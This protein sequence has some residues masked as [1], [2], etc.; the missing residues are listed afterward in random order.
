MANF[1]PLQ[2]APID[3]EQTPQPQIRPA[4]IQKPKRTVTLG[5]CVA[6]RKRKSKCDG[7]RPVCTCCAQKVTECVYELGPNEK[8]SQ[9]MKRKNEEMQSEL[10]NLRQ[11][12]DCLRL[13]PE[14]EAQQVLRRIRA[15]SSDT[16]PSQRIQELA[17]FVRHGDPNLILQPSLMQSPRGH[18]E[19]LT[20][21]PIRMALDATCA[22]IDSFSGSLPSFSNDLLPMRSDGPASQRRR[23]ASDADVS[24]RSDSQGTFPP[25]TSIEAI[26]QKPTSSSPPEL[27]D[28]RIASVRHWTTI[29]DDSNLL[30]HLMSAWYTWEYV[31]Y[32]FLDW[33]LF[34]D[35]MVSGRTD[36]CSRLLVHALLASAS[37]QS[38][39]VNDRAKP[40]AD[41]VLTLFY[42]EARRLWELEEGQDSLPRLQSALLLF[43]VLGKHGR[44]KVG[45]TFLVEA[46]RI[47]QDL[48]LFT[49]SETTSAQKPQEVPLE[50]LERARTV[51]AWALFNFQLSMSFTYAFP[52]IIKSQ[53]P[54][55]LPYEDAVNSQVLF[56]SECGRHVLMLESTIRH[57][58]PHRIYTDIASRPE[59][60]ENF[61]LRLQSWWDARPECLNPITLRRLIMLHELRHG[62]SNAIPYILHGITVTSFGC[63]EELAQEHATRHSVENSEPLRG[64]LSC[65]KALST[66]SNYVFYSQPLF[67]LLTQSCQTMGI[68]L[69]TE[70]TNTLSCYQTEEWTKNAA[71]IVSSQYVA[72][73]GKS[74]TD[75][76]NKQMDVIVRMWDNLI[77][78]TSTNAMPTRSILGREDEMQGD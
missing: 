51:T 19:Q 20:L 37:F 73:I 17:D 38:S 15:N 11:I 26:L 45:Y 41:N 55:P 52:I 36:F 64:L 59:W 24:A 18:S 1:R 70:T 3:Q 42:R 21:P 71:N 31:Y 65:L 44:D 9:A 74:A 27:I 6:C 77:L 22:V 54:L 67:R 47:A 46:C 14:H 53:P 43:V 7:S 72:D 28:P 66:L 32:H 2:P 76:T 29:T 57:P 61:Y 48:G 63:L 56:R 12:Y 30:V 75:M 35:D 39:L 58:E 10:S 50:K 68:A 62:W 40:F 49:L 78:D 8:P 60:T 16:T 4:L 34:L 5:A 23:H 25:V 13:R 69:P 33:D